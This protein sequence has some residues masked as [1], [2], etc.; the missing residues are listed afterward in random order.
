MITRSWGMIFS[1]MIHSDSFC[2]NQFYSGV[3]A[4]LFYSATYPFLFWRGYFIMHTGHA[5][6]VMLQFK[7]QFLAG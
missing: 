1:D 5:A 2:W 7:C 6:K 4:W 3:F